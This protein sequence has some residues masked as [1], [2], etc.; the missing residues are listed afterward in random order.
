MMVS[1][2][3]FLL[4]GSAVIIYFISQATSSSYGTRLSD[5]KEYKVEAEIEELEKFYKDAK[6]VKTSKIRLQGKIIYINIEAEKSVTN[7]DIQNMANNCLE[8]L[9]T[10][11]K[12]YYDIQF[13]FTRESFVPYFG[14]KSSNNTIIS[15]TNYDLDSEDSTKK[16]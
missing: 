10:E 11:Q 13:V 16:E 14:S 2:F 7:E 15:W 12:A 6:G 9:T 5:I 3:C 8:K 4:M 1:I